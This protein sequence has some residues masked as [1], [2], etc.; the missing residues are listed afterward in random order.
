MHI[1]ILSENQKSLLGLVANFKKE[2][3]LVGGTAI[4]LQIGHRQSID[5]DLFKVS[6]IN[7][8]KILDTIIQSKANYKVNYSSSE[9][10]NVTVEGVKFTFFQYPYLIP[11]QTKFENYVTMPNLLDL[12]AMKAFALGRRSKWKD[13]VDLYFLIKSHFTIEQISERAL[14]FFADLFSEKLF[15]SQLAYHA[16]IDFEEEVM[17]VENTIPKEEIL[18]FLLDKA[19]ERF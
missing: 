2:Y 7:R 11:H 3:Y 1:E 6:T 12:A 9:Q 13:Y 8:K 10:L 18:S 16:T 14:V 4:A 5:F 19:T 17:F 15:R